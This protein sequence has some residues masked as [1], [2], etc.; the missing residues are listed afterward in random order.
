MTSQTSLEAQVANHEARIT[1]L[2]RASDRVEAK[3]DKI[4]W[5]TISSLAAALG[6]MVSVLLKK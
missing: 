3:I 2:E 4:L 6:S 1:S 5:F